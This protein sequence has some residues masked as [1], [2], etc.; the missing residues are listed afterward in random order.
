MLRRLLVGLVLGLV[1]GGGVA[2]ALVKGFALASFA[3]A[4]PLGGVS[5]AGGAALAYLLAGVTGVLVALVAGKP[6]WAKGAWIE[7]GLKAF[8]GALL[9][10]GGM[11]ALRRWV[12]LSVELPFGLGAGSLSQ[13]PAASLPIIATVLSVFYE[14]D[15]T[16]EPEGEAG[17]ETPDVK[18]VASAKTKSSGKARIAEPAEES[19]D[20]EQAPAKKRMKN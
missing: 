19:D 10:V 3:P 7:V 12:D 18:R 14:L 5:A 9:A 15:N 6:F 1:I 16:G 8:F 17:K 13:L 2:A 4:S 20:E 11:F